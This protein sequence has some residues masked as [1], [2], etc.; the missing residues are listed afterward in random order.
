[1][2]SQPEDFKTY[3]KIIKQYFYKNNVKVNKCYLHHKLSTGKF[4]ITN[5]SLCTHRHTQQLLKF[6][7][8]ANNFNK[9][10]DT[11]AMDFCLDPFSYKDKV[12]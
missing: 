11:L 3:T 8:K 1:M 4:N 10:N 9:G 6:S 2:Q 5:K 12:K 7:F